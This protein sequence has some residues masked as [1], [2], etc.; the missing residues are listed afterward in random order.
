V[1]GGGGQNELL[2]RKQRGLS[3]NKGKQKSQRG[4]AAEFLQSTRQKIK[5][6]SKTVRYPE[7]LRGSW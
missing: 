5:I 7:F 1:V 2:S 4:E 6:V 3:R